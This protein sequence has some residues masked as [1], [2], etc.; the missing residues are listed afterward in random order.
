VGVRG[1]DDTRALWSAPAERSDDGALDAGQPSGGRAKAVS[2]CACLRTPKSLVAIRKS[3]SIPRKGSGRWRIAALAVLLSRV[4]LAEVHAAAEGRPPGGFAGPA[5][6]NFE[7][8]SE[9]SWSSDILLWESGARFEHEAPGLRWDVALTYAA[10]VEDYEPFRP[11]DRVFGF[12]ERLHEDRFGGQATLRPKLA[13]SFTLILSGGAYEGFQDYRRVWIDNYYRQQYSPPGLPPIPGY[14]EA[15]PKGWN[16]AAGF[17]WE[18]QPATGFLE[19]RAGY[20]LDVV[21]PGYMLDFSRPAEPLVRGQDRLHTPS[22][23]VSFENVLGSRCRLLNEV[24]LSHTT[25]RELRVSWQGSLNFAPAERWVLRSYAGY[26]AEEPK[27]EAYWLGTTLEFE[28]GRSFTLL[29][30]LHYYHDTGEVLDPGV[31]TSAAPGLKSYSASLGAR[32][33]W[34]RVTLRLS[35]GPYFTDYEPVTDE[36]RVFTNLYNDR[37]WGLAQ[38]V[39]SVSF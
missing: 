2:R 29:A 4:W 18:Y 10:Y 3:S 9:V 12:A 16:V 31:L 36:S 14:V 34:S 5:V 39:V 32:F 27:F 35:L 28:L 24:Q 1:L 6:P 8:D 25:E 30:G 15:D 23:K 37:N 33:S 38:A 19:T 17:R 21:A 22:L 20:N 7:A 11:L 26:T 13:E